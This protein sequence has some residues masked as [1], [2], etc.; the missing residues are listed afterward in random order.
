MQSNFLR[1]SMKPYRLRCQAF[2]LIEL[3]TVI[4]I[5]GILAAILIPTVSKV[6]ESARSARCA[7]Q[8]R[9]ITMALLLYADANRGMLPVITEQDITW[10]QRLRDYLP[11][12]GSADTARPSEIFVCPSANYNGWTGSSLLRTYSATSAMMW[13]PGP[14][15]GL[16][17]TLPRPLAMI[18]M[19]YR[20]RIPLFT[21]AK[22]I[23][24]NANT[25]WCQSSYN[26]TAISPDLAVGDASQ[27]TR[28]DFRHGGR[29]NLAYADGSVRSVSFPQFKEAVTKDLY[30]GFAPKL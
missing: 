15:N 23:N 5:I 17:A 14:N 6:R 21:E 27:T 4:A 22:A 1:L 3:L 20:T 13:R 19:D 10:H 7:S 16:T 28:L 12:K 30:E 29:M 18:E 26:W 9:Q 2:T 11:A 24:N 8:S 25:Q